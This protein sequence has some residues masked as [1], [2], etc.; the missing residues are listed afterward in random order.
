MR[1]P[2]ALYVRREEAGRRG[3]R[4]DDAVALVKKLATMCE[5]VKYFTS[6]SPT[7]AEKHLREPASLSTYLK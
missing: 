4:L 7:I 6:A 3:N 1:G 5:L 2:A